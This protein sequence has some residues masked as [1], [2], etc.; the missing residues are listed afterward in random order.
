MEDAEKGTPT[1]AQ[2]LNRD[3]E[4]VSPW[5]RSRGSGLAPL[6]DRDRAS[7]IATWGD[8]LQ[9][10]ESTT[11]REV[12]ILCGGKGLRLGYAANGGPKPLIPVNGRPL[13][14]HVME[15]YAAQ[16][17]R[18][19]LLCLGPRA[20]AFVDYFRDASLDPSW[21][22][23]LLDTGPDTNTGGRLQRV[24]SAIE[25]DSFFCTYAD[26][27]ADLDLGALTRF[28]RSHGGI[29]TV[30]AVRPT[31]SFGLLDLA[32]DDRV[33]GFV[34]K[35][36]LD[37]WINGG[38][39]VFGRGVFDFLHADSILEVDALPALAARGELYAYRHDG[40]WRCLDTP[41]DAAELNGLWTR[42]R[43]AAPS[44][45]LNREGPAAPLT[46][47]TRERDEAPR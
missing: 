5:E 18:D 17:Y 43:Q 9:D 25:G 47:L 23:R 24:E 37:R 38:F 27:L 19:F 41:K 29:A 34:E 12:V 2:P 40:F 26:G 22:V 31:L 46:A 28:H 35:P 6:R 4:I 7:E 21:R 3:A 30:T 8:W 13:L 44:T 1:A 14:L 10:A 45:A 32:P 20:E 42:E 15:I 16:G 33:R 39:F 36:V 11:P